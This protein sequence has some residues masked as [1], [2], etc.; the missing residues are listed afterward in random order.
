MAL[1]QGID[2]EW[3]GHSGFRLMQG[4]KAIYIDPFKVSEGSA[5]L[6]LVTHEHYDH[7]DPQSVENLR[8]EDTVVIASQSC[9]PKL[10]RMLVIKEGGRRTE[11]G[12]TTEAVPA[13]NIDK[14]YHPRGIGVGYVIML[15]EKRIY[16]AGDTDRIP[17]MKGLKGIDLALL[18][19]G[20]TYT[21]S[22]EEAAAAVNEDIK[23]KAAIP[24]HYG[25][26]VGTHSDAERFRRLCKC[27]VVLL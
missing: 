15:G 14:P 7:C 1:V 12:I 21:M 5:D 17:E 9:M 22:A 24:M 4:G 16:H 18:P 23:P 11:K 8:S 27:E 20:G 2:I 26:I 3:L 6:I 25:S 10:G 13:Y 19:V